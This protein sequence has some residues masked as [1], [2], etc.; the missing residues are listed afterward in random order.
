MYRV[1]AGLA[2]KL[3]SYIMVLTI[4]ICLVISPEPTVWPSALG[5]VFP[6]RPIFQIGVACSLL[7]YVVYLTVWCMKTK[8]RNVK[9]AATLK[10]I[11]LILSTYISKSDE[12]RI[13]GIMEFI[14]SMAVSYWML[15]LCWKGRR[16]SHLYKKQQKLGFREGY[17][18]VYV[19]SFLYSLRK[20]SNFYRTG[21]G[22]STFKRLRA[23]AVVLDVSFDYLNYGEFPGMYL[24]CDYTH[25][26]TA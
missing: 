21:S 22:Y 23:F 20:L 13:H 11:F 12:P 19:L 15:A 18:V 2:V 9:F 14:Y 3:S 1:E 26:H 10:F 17:L 4:F 16:G 6:S 7:P 8:S 25:Q 5:S 24:D